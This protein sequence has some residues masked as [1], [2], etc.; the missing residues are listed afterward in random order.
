MAK[1]NSKNLDIEKTSRLLKAVSDPD[2]LRLVLQLREG[3]KNVSTLANALGAEIVN[4]SHHLGVLRGSKVVRDEKVGR[5]VYY[6]LN[7]DV[8][9]TEGGALQ[10]HMGGC[11]LVIG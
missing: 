9:S 8:I 4:I 11:R 7:P 6:T 1:L 3:K 2:R 10:V 5:F